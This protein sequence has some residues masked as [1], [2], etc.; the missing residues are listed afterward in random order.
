M[1]LVIWIGPDG[2]VRA[3]EVVEAVP[4]SHPFT[5][6]ELSEPRWK[7]VSCDIT[8][9]EAEGLLAAPMPVPGKTLRW[10]RMR[11]SVDGLPDTLTRAELYARVIEP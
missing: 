2:A 3:G 1:K 8:Q 5:P 11:L 9:A 6:A 7:I 10:R 4:D